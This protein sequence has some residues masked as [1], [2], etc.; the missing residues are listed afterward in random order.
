MSINNPKYIL[1]HCSA[2]SRKKAPTQFWAIN[3]Y[4]GVERGFPMSSMGYFGGYH[5]FYEPNGTE[6][7]Y[8]RDWEVG[9]H[10][11]SKVNGVSMNFQSISLCWG[12]DGD[13]ETPT[14]KQTE[15]MRIRI[16]KLVEK[17]NIP[18]TNIYVGPHRLWTKWKTCYGK[19]LSDDW[20]YLLVKPKE[21]LAYER[22]AEEKI[23]DMKRKLDRVREIILKI[24][25]RL[26]KFF[27][28]RK[29]K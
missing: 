12:G 3:R 17:Y 9:A 26:N 29:I 13:N 11:N 4:H 24:M 15:N 1:V 25:I 18:L 23:A 10:C 8:K 20:A 2:V 5:F 14:P 28:G 27:K 19:M 16:K 6:L 21:K 7:R 22:E